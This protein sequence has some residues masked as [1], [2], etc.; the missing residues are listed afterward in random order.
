MNRMLAGQD[1]LRTREHDTGHGIG[2]RTRDMEL[3]TG[4]GTEHWA[5]TGNW[6]RDGSRK[7]GFVASADWLK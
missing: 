4:H 5:R 1:R 6:T 7:D 2:R 3:D